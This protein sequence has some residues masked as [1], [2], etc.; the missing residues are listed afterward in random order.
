MNRKKNL[1]ENK[2]ERKEKEEEIMKTL[3]TT[4][5]CMLTSKPSSPLRHKLR[6][7]QGQYL[8]SLTE[9]DKHS[10]MEPTLRRRPWL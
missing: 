8:S 10:P 5:K 7:S 6:P 4:D 1:P 2:T 3:M 9:A